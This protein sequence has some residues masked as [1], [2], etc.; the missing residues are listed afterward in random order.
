M[1]DPPV[2]KSIR[3]SNLELLGILIGAA[4]LVVTMYFGFRADRSKSLAI[5][6]VGK[7]S[8][9]S[10]AAAGSKGLRVSY[11]DQ[12][13]SSPWLI[14]ARLE[15]NGSLPIESRDIEVPPTLRFGRGRILGV[16]M[17][18]KSPRSV[19]ATVTHTER[20]VSVVH[21]LLN[22]GDWISISILL[23]GEPDI[24]EVEMRVS[25]I[26]RPVVF[27]P[28]DRP[29]E[30]RPTLFNIPR[31]FEYVAL[32]LSSIGVLLAGVIAFAAFADAINLAPKSVSVERGQ[33][34]TLRT[35][36]S[37]VIS[38][39]QFSH[40]INVVL[41][42]LGRPVDVRWMDEPSTLVTA[43][44][45]RVPASVLEAYGLSPTSAAAR[46]IP[47]L[48]IIYKEH[49]ARS[50]W[51]ILPRGLDQMIQQQILSIE[52][53]NRS[54]EDF[55]RL[56]KAFLDGGRGPDHSPIAIPRRIDW[57]IFAIGVLLLVVSLAG[58][59][60]IGGAWQLV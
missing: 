51:A 10:P 14:S 59:L 13:V 18:G 2:Q 48:R 6:Y 56:A 60:V 27:L 39:D 31:P 23:D 3:R 17:S 36:D 1:D 57:P 41:L 37:V 52:F 42:A 16:Q 12:N 7:S 38:P 24:P 26:T 8:L 29:V 44:Q 25:G 21:K 54:V 30:H 11:L 19:E 22:P 20:S 43:I 46:A 45:E 55:N 58:F 49:V 15:N 50:A 5:R 53:E 9:M 47:E 28:T 34:R 4:A 32:A 40:P 33:L 35:G